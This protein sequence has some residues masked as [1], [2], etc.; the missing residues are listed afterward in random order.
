MEAVI[1]ILYLLPTLI[2]FLYSCAQLSLVWNYWRRRQQE[3][4]P[5]R[6]T[7]ALPAE[8]SV[9]E[10]SPLVTVQL[11]IY[12]ERYVIE[13]LIDAVAAFDY[14]KN[15][16]EIQILDDSTDDTVSIVAQKV[17]HYQ[18]LGYQ[19]SQVRR[20]QREGFKAGALAYGLTLAQGEFVAIFDADFVPTPD[21]LQKTL[22]HFSDANVGVVQTRWGHLNESYSLMTQLQAFGLDG[23]FVVEQGGRN[24]GGHFI[25]FNGTAGIWRKN[26]ITDA[27]GWES[28]T[29]TEDLDLSYRAQV[30]GWRFAY[31]ETLETPAELP[32]TMPALKSQQYRWMKGA[33]ECARKNLWKV[34]QTST[35]KLST[36][37]HA[38]FH[39]LN[40]GV[41]VAVLLMA[42]LSLPTLIITHYLP[43][44]A[45]MLGI[46]RYF[47]VSVVMLLAFYWTAHHRRKSL[48]ELLWKLP[49]FLSVM[50]GLSLH[51]A[52]AVMEGYLGKKTPFVRTPKWG[53]VQKKD[54]WQQ[55][56]YLVKS[57]NALT[58][59][60]LALSFY[61][62][63]GVALGLYW[64]SY[65]ML[66]LHLL[67]AFGYGF[68][69]YFSVK[70]S[71][72]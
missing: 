53:I 20:P 43:E 70:H 66:L 51:N 37:I 61:F 24:A 30:R 6:R 72:R 3:S 14:P 39:L 11:P 25:N 2:L 27:G 68:I 50:L 32:V 40:S 19:I 26:C 49:V 64:Q 59:M 31:L 54:G 67:L 52:I 38:A 45:Y 46:F 15:R 10:Q 62:V 34:F 4:S 35:I 58:V 44:Y 16:F 13:R 69:G 8:D 18:A 47:Q 41:F 23:H 36:K 42:L 9:L 21:F 48:L 7:G 71:L 65:Q 60:E 28:N 17:V 55:K 5:L 22:P 1:V 56:K 57:L 29:L 12:N 33:A 63:A